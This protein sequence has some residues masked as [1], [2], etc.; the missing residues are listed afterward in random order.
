[1]L[2]VIADITSLEK[3]ISL[4]RTIMIKH[5]CSH[6]SISLVTPETFPT[7]SIETDATLLFYFIRTYAHAS[8]ANIVP[9]LKKLVCSHSNIY[10][11]IED[12][13]EVEKITKFCR[14]F[15][16]K[17]IILSMK[18]DMYETLFK[19]QDFHVDILH[20]CFD[21]RM[22]PREPPEKTYDILLYGNANKM[23][24]PIRSFLFK[25]LEK[26]HYKY[27]L[28]YIPMSTNYKRNEHSV[29][30][31]CLYREISRA[32]ICIATTG[33]Y[34][35]FTKKYQEIPLCH[36]VILGNMP[37]NYQSIFENFMLEF[38]SL[39]EKKLIQ[40]IDDCLLEYEMWFSKTKQLAEKI[41]SHF[42]MDQTFCEMKTIFPK[43]LEK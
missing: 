23:I 32:K 9:I 38:N 4:N 30:R 8:T 7:L 16:V 36:T 27:K 31:D 22:F 14:C 28:K 19:K 26:Y 20:H 37:L 12:F 25:T 43:I 10:F 29:T 21:L 17:N 13:Y 5:W 34:G 40:M 1:M 6:D 11:Y 33:K 15:H 24:Y 35:F 18:H 2:Y 39:D 41:R 3:E 42:H